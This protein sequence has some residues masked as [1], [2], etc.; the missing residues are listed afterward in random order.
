MTAKKSSK[1]AV[2]SQLKGTALTVMEALDA[3]LNAEIPMTRLREAAEALRAL[4]EVLGQME[5]AEK[6]AEAA[7]ALK[8]Q[9]SSSSR[10]AKPA[11]AERIAGVI[12]IARVLEEVETDG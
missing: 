9:K 3:G 10:S 2:R 12:E 1:A 4:A 11:E 7:E 8:R 6:L 5:S